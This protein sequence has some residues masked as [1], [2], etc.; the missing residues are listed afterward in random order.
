MGNEYIF[1][2]V[3]KLGFWHNGIHIYKD[4]DLSVHSKFIG[5]ILTKSMAISE[6]KIFSTKFPPVIKKNEVVIKNQANFKSNEL[7]EKILIETKNI[8]GEEKKEIFDMIGLSSFPT[9]ILQKHQL[10]YN[11]E[12]FCFFSFTRHLSKLYEYNNYKRKEYIFPHDKIGD[13]GKSEGEYDMIHQEYFILKDSNFFKNHDIDIFDY[14]IIDSCKNTYKIREQSYKKIYF[15]KNT[16]FNVLNKSDDYINNPNSLN[17]QIC[18]YPVK[19]ENDYEEKNNCFINIKD[20]R[21]EIYDKEQKKINEI[22]VIITNPYSNL[23][24]KKLLN[25]KI[26]EVNGNSRD[27]LFC[28]EDIFDIGKFW[29]KT[30]ISKLQH[31]DN[32]IFAKGNICLEMYSN[33]PDKK[34]FEKGEDIDFQNCIFYKVSS[35][36]ITILNS[37]TNERFVKIKK[38]PE[39]FFLKF[40]DINFDFNYWKMFKENTKIFFKEDLETYNPN[41]NEYKNFND[42]QSILNKKGIIENLEENLLLELFLKKYKNE[43]MKCGFQHISEWS[44][45]KMNP[46]KVDYAEEVFDLWRN[47]HI[48]GSNGKANNLPK[49][50]SDSNKFI[51][52]H[53]TYFE[54]WLYNLHKCFVEKLKATQDIV[55]KDWRMIQGNCGIYYNFH[56]WSQ[57]FC[58]QAVYTTIKMVDG[59]YLSFLLNINEPAW[60]LKKYKKNIQFTNFLKNNDCLENGKYKFKESNLWFDILDYQSTK[61]LET[62]IAKITSE[63]AFYMAQLGYVV[64]AA[65]KNTSK[66][67]SP[68]FVTLRPSEGVYENIKNLKVVHIGIDKNMEKKLV[69]AFPDSGNNTKKY[70]EVLFFCNINQKFI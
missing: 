49:E 10:N 4:N 24:E 16:R 48:W 33:P 55:M 8:S 12:S 58:N 34:I 15:S 52:F 38:G 56:S 7:H 57:T 39:S 51:Y 50:I 60:D 17:L 44:K 27:D 36:S 13:F 20:N 40:D 53:P 59:N 9:Y 54:S 47:L 69:D 37:L 14:S 22:E 46:L 35:N 21:I 2:P 28:V 43:I 32:Y 68:H 18:K 11:S 3:T 65:W 1:F 42:L 66:N 26:L 6:E 64:I 61:T 19:I 63:Q 23:Q 25:V 45:I 62:G 29:T 31:W 67:G 70:K 30:D 5:E 41:D